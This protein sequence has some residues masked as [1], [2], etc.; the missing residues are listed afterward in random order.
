MVIIFLILSKTAIDSCPLDSFSMPVHTARIIQDCFQANHLDFTG[1][2][3]WLPNTPDLDT[4]NYH[5]WG[6][7]QRLITSAIQN[8]KKCQTERNVAVN[9]AQSGS[10]TNRQGCEGI[11][12]ATELCCSWG[13]TSRTFLVNAVLWIWICNVF[14][15]HLNNITIH[16]VYW[17]TLKCKKSWGSYAAVFINFRQFKMYVYDV[18]IDP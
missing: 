12:K 8:W 9:L 14:W 7:F 11:S 13:W 15:C 16:C 17:Y 10:G 5:V 18:L 2:D 6:Q 1:K 4:P 3:Q